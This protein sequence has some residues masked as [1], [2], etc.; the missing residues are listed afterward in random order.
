MNVEHFIVVVNSRCWLCCRTTQIQIVL[1]ALC[2]SF[3]SFEFCTSSVTF[4]ASE[5]G[6]M[7]VHPEP[8]ILSTQLDIFTTSN[9]ASYLRVDDDF[10]QNLSNYPMSR[11]CS[12]WWRRCRWT[13]QRFFSSS[14]GS[15]FGAVRHNESDWMVLLWRFHQRPSGLHEHC[16]VRLFIMMYVFFHTMDGFSVFPN[17]VCK[18]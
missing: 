16:I 8:V 4:S 6:L 7:G 12:C 1:F 3:V 11:R 15:R 18:Q 9:P 10:P 13:K 2:F 17:I 14:F 5:D